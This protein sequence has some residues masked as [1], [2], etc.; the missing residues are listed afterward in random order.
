VNAVRRISGK[1]RT[2]ATDAA[3]LAA[4]AQGDLTA[5][6]SLFD[7]HHQRVERVLLRMGVSPADADDLVQA[8]FIEVV[9]TARAFDGRD[10]SAAWLCGI[11]VRLAARRRRSVA[12]LLRMLTVFSRERPV[13]NPVDPEREVASREELARFARAL[14]RLAPKKR[15]AFVLIEIEGLSAED[16]GHALGVNAATI[17]TRL[18]HARSELRAAMSRETSC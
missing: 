8:T 5:L 13:L 3:L 12:R 4:I 14:D 2:D 10:S 16:V 18:F 15:E 11:A 7:R 1:A 6:G 9:K 17:R